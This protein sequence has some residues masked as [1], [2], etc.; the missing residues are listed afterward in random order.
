MLDMLDKT[1][2]R[3]RESKS[4][5]N[6]SLLGRLHDSL[7]CH[8]ADFHLEVLVQAGNSG[9]DAENISEEAI[10]GNIHLFILAGHE[11]AANTLAIAIS[12][13]AYHPEI[14]LALQKDLDSILGDPCVT[15]SLEFEK[16]YPRLINGY[17]GALL[18][19]TL[20]LYPTLPFITKTTESEPRELATEDDKQFV[21]P[22]DTLIVINIA[23]AHRNPQYWSSNC[24]SFDPSR[25]LDAESRMWLS[26][27]AGTYLPFSEGFRSCVGKRFAQVEFC[28]VI[29]SIFSEYSVRLAD[30]SGGGD[31]LPLEDMDSRMELLMTL[32]MGTDA[33]LQFIKREEREA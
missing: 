3:L 30:G 17:T 25:W 6:P 5:S 2:L 7:L 19:E 22:A 12:L 33:P 11:T 14:Q 9:T 21:V 27:R 10:L 24:S 28:A 16:H 13:L 31:R 32:K 15:R 26:P 1:R 23:A 8:I 4:Q 29:S 18:Y 20:R